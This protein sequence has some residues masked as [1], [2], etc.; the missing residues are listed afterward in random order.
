MDVKS[1]TPFSS[2]RSL[3]QRR[4]NI[5]PFLALHRQMNNMFDDLFRGIGFPGPGLGLAQGAAPT[6]MA[7][8]VNI[9]E[10][11]EAIQI[12]AEL[13]GI[14][15]DDV[16]V[17]VTD[18]VLTIRGET[19]TERQ[20][21]DKDR[22][23]HLVERVQGTF[24]RSLQLPFNVDPSA[25]QA[26][27]KNGVLTLTIPKPREVQERTHRITVQGGEDEAKS[28]SDAKKLRIDRAAAGDK[29]GGTSSEASS[30]GHSSSAAGAEASTSN[31]KSEAAAS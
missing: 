13:P 22:D 12:A 27:F 21:D 29:P 24:A 6:V 16:E 1:L 7:P 31:K 2:N 20:E 15:P 9:S 4:E 25:V 14:A 11:P 19:E 23:Y 17:T 5:D 28:G 30:S 3:S 18:D 10:T 26:E 8:R